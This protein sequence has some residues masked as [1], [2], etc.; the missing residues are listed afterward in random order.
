MSK[1][2][3]CSFYIYCLC[4]VV[5]KVIFLLSLKLHVYVSDNFCCNYFFY[6]LVKIIK[7]FCKY[8]TR[9]FIFKNTFGIVKSPLF[10]SRF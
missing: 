5:R 10:I 4:Y 3:K 7:L 8:F 2:L 9:I 6:I 1:I